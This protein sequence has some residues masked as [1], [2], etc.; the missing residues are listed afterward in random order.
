MP[1]KPNPNPKPVGA[2]VSPPPPVPPR[3]KTRRANGQQEAHVPTDL[4][5]RT[6]SL[7]MFIGYTQEQIARLIEVD[8]KTLRTHYPDE[9]ARGAERIGATIAGNLLS[10]A[11]QQQDRKAALTA[12]IFIAKTRLHW[13]ERDPFVS[14]AE[15]KIK[16][17]E[18][19]EE[20]VT[21]TLK[22]GDREADD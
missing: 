13:R 18:D 12:C 1:R 17:T 5:R 20:T 8:E 6:V 10:I 9:L 16:R 15:A 14:E 11:T 22:I 7:G 21:V 3:I 4:T 2:A 19:G